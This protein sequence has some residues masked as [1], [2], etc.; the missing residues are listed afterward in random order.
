MIVQLTTTD[1]I[2]TIKVSKTVE[3]VLG[4]KK[5]ET[6]DSKTKNEKR[7]TEAVDFLTTTECFRDLN[8]AASICTRDE[9]HG[10]SGNRD[11]N[12]HV[13]SR[14]AAITRG[15]S[16]VIVD[17]DDCVGI[18]LGTRAVIFPRP[19]FRRDSCLVPDLFPDGDSG[20]SPAL[21]V[22]VHHVD[23]ENRFSVRRRS[24]ITTARKVELEA[25][26]Y[27]YILHSS[28]HIRYIRLISWG[29]NHCHCDLVTE[30]RKCLG[31]A[32]IFCEGREG[33]IKSR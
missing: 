10:Q 19:N 23:E 22:F 14:R 5:I 32:C 20:R 31:K 6:Y 16:R 11:Q 1:P 9:R 21:D 2:S 15:I 28:P 17:P 8:C 4:S 27:T 25:V 3:R 33:C 24:G 7:K 12:R 30:G 26:L 18:F 29:I 13:P